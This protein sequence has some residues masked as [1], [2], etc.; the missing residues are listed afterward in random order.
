MYHRRRP[1]GRWILAIALAVLGA[2]L[3][4]V[5]ALVLDAAPAGASVSLKAPALQFPWR[6]NTGQRITGYG[7]NCGDTHHGL[8]HYALDFNFGS[9]TPVT[10]AAV[11][12]ARTGVDGAG[13]LYVWVNH[14]NGFVTTYFHL[15]S[16]NV[17][18]GQ[19]VNQGQVIGY[20]GSTGYSTGPH[21]HFAVHQQSFGDAWSGSAYRPEPMFG[22]YR[23]GD[24]G[25]HA[26]GTCAGGN[27]PLYI[28]KPGCPSG[29]S[30]TVFNRATAHG[31]YVVAQD[32]GVFAYGGALFHGSTGSMQL[33]AL[34]TGMA[35]TFD[36]QGYW[37]VGADG[38]IFAYGTAPFNGSSGSL[39]LVSCIQGMGSRSDGKYWLV[40][41]DGGVFAYPTTGG[42]FY[43]SMG[44]QFL[45][46]RVQG[47]SP[48]P[49]G[50]GYWLVAADGGVFA[51]GN[52]QYFGSLVG[53]A[54]AP[55]TSIA[56]TPTGRGYWLLQAD[57]TVVGYGDAPNLG[58]V[59]NPI[60]PAV[61]IAPTTNG[62]GYW[63]LLSDGQVYEFGTAD[64]F[65][66]LYG[67]INAPAVGIAGLHA[68]KPDFSMSALPST[69]VVAPGT[70]NDV[71]ITVTAGQT[72]QGTV[73][74]SASGA[75]SG[76]SATLTPPAISLNRNQAG[77]STLR[78]TRAL[79]HIG[80][81]TVTV[82]GCGNGV[83]HS[84]PVTV[85]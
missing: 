84:V 80:S 22:P 10:A 73:S 24:A 60:A 82:T 63:V 8:D 74:L 47:M 78:I 85:N 45:A 7:Y 5:P 18:N 12:R 44:G 26:Y 16:F 1:L 56:S 42:H 4:T 29:A 21:L 37:L 25:F 59:F 19:W 41:A 9:G 69:T 70:S 61:G 3:A 34:M 35:R 36:N 71:T 83:C 50:G 65:G 52:A 11:G 39:N 58:S 27:S 54:T 33:N 76:S 68:F 2:T 20:S 49:S 53:S 43:G 40:A 38:G 15:S 67:T 51:F 32:G 57:G 66:G 6:D 62:D 55:V 77:A 14:G 17:L 13:A 64:N 79:S 46:A 75:H 30:T 31:Y 23:G 28:S 72:F 81:F 48:T